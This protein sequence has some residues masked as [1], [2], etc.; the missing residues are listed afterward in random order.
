[1]VLLLTI[2][3]IPKKTLAG[4]F[5]FEM[6]PQGSAIDDEYLLLGRHN[7]SGSK[8]HYSYAS[9]HFSL[10]VDGK[11]VGGNYTAESIYT[12][13]HYTNAIRKQCERLAKKIPEKMMVY[14]N[15]LC[16]PNNHAGSKAKYIDVSMYGKELADPTTRILAQL[17][18]IEQPDGD[19]PF[20]DLTLAQCL[21][22]F[23]TLMK[24]LKAPL[25][26]AYWN[27]KF[28]P[29]EKVADEAIP[30]LQKFY[31]KNPRLKNDPFPTPFA[32]EELFTI[33]MEE[34]SSYRKERERMVRVAQEAMNVINLHYGFDSEEGTNH[35]QVTGIVAGHVALRLKKKF[36]VDVQGAIEKLYKLIF[37]VVTTT[38]ALSDA[39]AKDDVDAVIEYWNSETWQMALKK[40]QE[41][42]DKQITDDI[43][44][45]Q[46]TLEKM[47]YEPHRMS[48]TQAACSPDAQR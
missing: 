21:D 2:G 43:K 30:A 9:P 24:R 48:L 45:L 29:L 5:S 8:F 17:N 6:Q 12:N 18:L 14:K 23:S 46:T 20:D 10:Y 39:E 33:S 37:E 44:N 11:R 42:S 36:D 13:E 27:P 34:N 41:A 40:M 32:M 47:A 19:P 3:L 28:G 26:V 31:E 15:R 4:T 38:A 7:E 16:V 22:L 35:G 1:M 25:P